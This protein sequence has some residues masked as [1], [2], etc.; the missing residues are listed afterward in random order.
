MSACENNEPFALMV[1]GG[2]MAPE[3]EDG[4]V[5]TIDPSYPLVVGAYIIADIEGELYFRQY[6][7]DATGQATLVALNDAVTSIP[8][9][10]NWVHKGT[11]VQSARKRCYT[12]YEY[13]Q[14]EVMRQVRDR[15][16]KQ[17]N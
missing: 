14:G 13:H 10:N 8:L 1:L 5:I 3:F 2:D 16:R 12:S 6:Q 9:D 15:R 11:V 4:D 17:H 7:C